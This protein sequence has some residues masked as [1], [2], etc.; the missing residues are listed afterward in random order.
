MLQEGAA[1]SKSAKMETVGRQSFA[2]KNGWIQFYTESLVELKNLPGCCFQIS[3]KKEI[4]TLLHS[5]M[6]QPFG[7]LVD[8]SNQSE[9][10]VPAL[11]L[12]G[13]HPLAKRVAFWVR[14]EQ[15]SLFS[16]ATLPFKR[17]EM[18]REIRGFTSRSEALEWLHFVS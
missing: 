6:H 11:N 15:L 14:Q 10:S 9:F 12:P 17:S 16:D 18:F 3:E 7:V 1:C 2:L 13:P 5:Q 8:R 4:S